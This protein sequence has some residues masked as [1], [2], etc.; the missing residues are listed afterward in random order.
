VTPV[1]EDERAD[2]QDGNGQKVVVEHGC[3]E[4]VSS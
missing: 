1:L 4:L 2:E 3:T